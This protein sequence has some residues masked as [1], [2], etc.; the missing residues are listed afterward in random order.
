[1]LLLFFLLISVSLITLGWSKNSQS[2][3][4]PIVE[5]RYVPRTFVEEQENPVSVEDIF[6]DMFK[7][8]SAW[9][10]YFS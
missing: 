6:S 2:C 3:P 7:K 4:P 8:G 5:Y 10:G 1:M 9:R